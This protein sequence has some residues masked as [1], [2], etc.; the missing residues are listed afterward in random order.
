[1]IK[2]ICTLVLTLA[3]GGLLGCQNSSLVEENFG[4]AYREAVARSTDDPEGSAAN[5][6]LPAPLGTDGVTAQQSLGRFRAG[7]TPAAAPAIPLPMI[8]TDSESLSS[9]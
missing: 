3:L 4:N 5:A 8:V 2:T 7:M 6:D 1:M 9:D